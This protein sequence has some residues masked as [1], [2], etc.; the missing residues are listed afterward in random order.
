M[1]IDH[2]TTFPFR[3]Y[4]ANMDDPHFAARM[5]DVTVHGFSLSRPT[6]QVP[7][8]DVTYSDASTGAVFTH[9]V[10]PSAL[11]VTAAEAFVDIYFKAATKL[12]LMHDRVREAAD[13]LTRVRQEAQVASD[14]VKAVRDEVLKHSS[15]LHPGFVATVTAGAAV[16]T[17]VFWG[18][19]AA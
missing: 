17:H 8:L 9:R 10:P 3:A 4:Y 19:K 6:A 16:D 11:H 15:A 18:R 12:A 2:T 14:L 13:Q 1:T 7:L 5:L